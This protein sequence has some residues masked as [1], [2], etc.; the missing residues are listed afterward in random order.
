MLNS[1]DYRDGGEKEREPMQNSTTRLVYVLPRL[2]LAGVKYGQKGVGIGRAEFWPDEDST[3]TNVIRKPRPAWLDIFREFPPASGRGREA[4]V[5]RGTLL[6]ADDDEW[7]RDNAAKVIPILYYA[8]QSEDHWQ[9]PAEAFQ[10][11]QFKAADTPAALVSLMT[12]YGPLLEDERSLR[13]HPPLG[14]RPGPV[15]SPRG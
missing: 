6:V 8:G 15:P 11:S 12:K 14:L 13:V 9:T 4:H 3:W 1:E 7:L 10:Y 2:K 5:A